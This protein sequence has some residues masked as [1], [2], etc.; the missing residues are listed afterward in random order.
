M[1]KR[2]DDFKPFASKVWQ[3]KYNWDNTGKAL[4]L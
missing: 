4:I 3:M 2:K 1:F